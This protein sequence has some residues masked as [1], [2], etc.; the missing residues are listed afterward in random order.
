MHDTM[1]K[2]HFR[3]L[4]PIFLNLLFSF[5]TIHY[6]PSYFRTSF[7]RN[8]KFAD[9]RRNKRGSSERRWGSSCVWRTDDN[10][11]AFTIRQAFFFIAW[12]VRSLVVRSWLRL[13]L[14]LGYDN[15]WR[16]LLLLRWGLLMPHTFLLWQKLRVWW[17]WGLQRHSLIMI[18][19]FTPPL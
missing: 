12:V 10:D 15:F 19:T 17:W 1:E 13:W 8:G 7:Q 3:I 11:E 2:R 14:G 16:G 18:V 5:L 4:S 9:S 6:S